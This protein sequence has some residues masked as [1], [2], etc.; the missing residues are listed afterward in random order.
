ETRASVP[1]VWNSNMSATPE[2]QDLL[3][4]LVCCY[5]ADLKYGAE[6]CARAAS[7]VSGSLEVVH[8]N[9]RRARRE[10][11]LIVRHL[12]L[13]GHVDGCARPALDWLAVHLP[14]VRVNVMAQYEPVPEVRGT[15]W[16]RRVRPD[17]VARARDHALALGL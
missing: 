3:E 13:P 12:V 11:Y 8:H 10:A 7:A 1:V 6:A 14:G 9:L 15:A 5:V 16:D 2:A 17:E 4:G